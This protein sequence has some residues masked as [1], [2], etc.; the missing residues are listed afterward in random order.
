MLSRYTLEL[1]SS[2]KA[3]S[4]IDDIEQRHVVN[5]YYVDCNIVVKFDVVLQSKLESA[6]GFAVLLAV[7]V[8]FC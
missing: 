7:L 4:L 8:V 6:G 1:F 3:Y 5:V 2:L